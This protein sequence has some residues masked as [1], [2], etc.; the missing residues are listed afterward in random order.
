M[1]LDGTSGVSATSYKAGTKV[2]P[3]RCHHANLVFFRRG[4]EKLGRKKETCLEKSNP[5]A[6]KD[7]ELNIENNV[8]TFSQLTGFFFQP[9]SSQLSRGHHDEEKGQAFG[10]CRSSG[11]AWWSVQLLPLAPPSINIHISPTASI[12]NPI[13]MLPSLQMS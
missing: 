11:E 6:S 12:S 10:P 7:E 1:F 9:P 4:W 3:K 2:L 13:S 5:N 8:Q